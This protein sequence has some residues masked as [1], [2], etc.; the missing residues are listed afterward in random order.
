MR[1]ETVVQ[2]LVVSS[3]YSHMTDYQLA[4]IVPLYML[5]ALYIVWNTLTSHCTLTSGKMPD[6]PG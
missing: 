3:E 2:Q 6:S 4:P 1:P 5:Y